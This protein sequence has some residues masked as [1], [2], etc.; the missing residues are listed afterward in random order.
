MTEAEAKKKWCPFTRIAE[1]DTTINRGYVDLT[2]CIAS[3]CMAWRWDGLFRNTG[4]C[5]LASRPTSAALD[6]EPEDD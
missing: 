5:G 1:G 6:N 2:C 4:Y 3:A